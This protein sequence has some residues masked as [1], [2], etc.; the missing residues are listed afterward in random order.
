MRRFGKSYAHPLVLLVILPA[1][2]EKSRFG[3]VAGRS[4]GN[5]VQRNKAKRMLREAVRS[6]QPQIKSGWDVILIARQPILKANL[7]E[8][9]TSLKQVFAKAQLIVN[10]AI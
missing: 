5:A 2:V 3:I 9:L 7:P 8:I 6:L 4:V 10:Y 1:S